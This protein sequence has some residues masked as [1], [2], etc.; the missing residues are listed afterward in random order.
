MLTAVQGIA[1]V[2]VAAFLACAI[3]LL[4]HFIAETISAMAG[5]GR[6]GFSGCFTGAAALLSLTLG[7]TLYRGAG[8]ATR[9]PVGH[10]VTV[11]MVVQFM[12]LL[13]CLGLN[14]WVTARLNESHVY[15]PAAKFPPARIALVTLVYVAVF[16][17][18]AASVVV[19]LYTRDGTQ[20]PGALW[21]ACSRILTGQPG[22]AR[23][24]PAVTNRA[25]KGEALLQEL[26]RMDWASHALVA[27]VERE[28]LTLPRAAT[29][30]T[31]YWR[32][33]QLVTAH[34][35]DDDPTGG[36]V[37]SAMRIVADVLM[38]PQGRAN[39]SG[40]ALLDS[41]HQYDDTELLQALRARLRQEGLADQ[42][43]VCNAALALGHP[44]SAAL[45]RAQVAAAVRDASRARA[46]AV[47]FA[48]NFG[49]EGKGLHWG[50]LALHMVK[51]GVHPT[52]ACAVFNDS[53][54]TPL[55]QR[56]VLYDELR[57]AVAD[58][59]PPDRDI[60][61]LTQAQ[62]RD[63]SGCG[64]YT[65]EN[66]VLM[67]DLDPRLESVGSLR[68][69]LQAVPPDTATLRRRHAEALMLEEG[70]T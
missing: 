60:W 7:Y 39:L 23:S 64:A 42:V 36:R 26:R 38:K 19:M 56:G 50:A 57:A 55:R 44:E 52:G 70:K 40:Y 35:G 68:A 34:L 16:S 54:G 11:F 24:A 29:Y 10:V 62:Q 20:L 28:L 32:L 43:F 61:D 25:Q 41:N 22:Q 59:L 58:H 66:L 8:D 63:S 51:A 21:D 4:S 33:H 3:Y 46:R 5:Y 27:D 15:M 30:E 45:V 65:V 47:G 49:A 2:C 9:Q 18:M 1:L 17:V 31:V 67:T 14:H 13:S 6:N 48:V 37:S 69:A 53:L 12:L